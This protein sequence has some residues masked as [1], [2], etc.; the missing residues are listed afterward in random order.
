MKLATFLTLFSLSS[1]ALAASASD[2]RSKSIYQV[3]TDRTTA[4]CNPV[5]KY[6]GGTYQGIIKQLDYIQN[7]GF[8]AIWISPIT[9]QIQT[10]TPYGEPWHGYWQQD[11]SVDY[12][13]FKPFDNV[14]YYHS[15]CNVDYSNDTS[16]RDCWLGDSNVEL[17]DLRTED[18][19]VAQ[20]YQIW[21]E[22]LVSNY[23][24][25]GLRID[26]VKHVDTDFWS[27]FGDAA[28]VFIT[29]EITN[30]DPY[31]LCPYQNYMDSVLNY[32]MYYAATA[33]FSST[34]GSMSG[35]V[36]Q[37]NGMKSQC[38]DTTVLGSFSENHDQPRFAS[39]T[40]DMSLAKNIIA[41]TI[42]GDGIPIIYEG[43]EQHFSGAQD[44][45]NREAV[46]LSGY[47]TDAPL[48]TFTASANQIRNHALYVDGDWL[49]YQNWV[50]YSDSANV[51]M[52]KGYDGYQTVTVLTNKGASSSN[53]TLSVTNTGYV[54]G[55]EVV[56]VLSCEALTAGQSGTL[57][58]P[59]SQGLPK[60]Y[61]PVEVLDCSGICG[62]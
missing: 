39:L 18:T 38:K 22:Q 10:W 20:E 44:P 30:G 31:G 36:K 11:L 28:G 15:Y 21:I 52:R 33:A 43:Q 19:S 29:G 57:T 42:M 9:F 16:I 45:Y 7:M 8:T 56:D 62:Y 34:S 47:N 53:Y 60:I 13:V 50:I 41:S 51:A 6:C 27:G 3:L 37:L 49:T 59:M 12:S 24:I 2:W 25:D 46:W 17:V 54:N 55:T 48:Y 35:F 4:K 1:S 26:T 61:Y 58:V 32:V 40:S 14:K 5:G 23:S